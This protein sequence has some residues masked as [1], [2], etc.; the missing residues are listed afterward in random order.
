MI[1][2]EGKRV[3][4]VGNDASALAATALARARGAEVR[5]WDAGS[6]EVPGSDLPDLVVL[7]A[8]CRVMP[9]MGCWAVQ[10]EIPVIGERE[11]AFQC[12]LCLHVAVTGACGKSTTVELLA[13][14][15]R[16]AGRRV[17]TAD[18]EDRPACGWVETSRDLDFLVHAIHP[19]EPEH[20]VYFRPVVAV[21]LNAPLDP[22][23]GETTG[24]EPMRRMSR[25]FAMQQAFDWAIVQSEALAV[26]RAVEVDLPGKLITFS[27]SSR[28]A[29][30]REE[31]GL[32]L[33]GLDGWSG[34]LWD[35][36]KGRMP[37]PHFAENALAALAAGRVLRLTLEQMLPSLAQFRAGPGRMEVLGEIGGVR[38]IDDGRSTTPNALSR[39]LSTLAPTTPD[40]PFVWLVAGGE[41]GG[42]QFYDL[43]P[44]LSP[45]VRHAFVLGEAASAMRSAW[46][47]FVPC[48]PAASLLD[49]VDRAMA[50]AEPGDV[51]LF[52]PACPI[53]DH[54]SGFAA[55]SPSFR[56]AFGQRAS[57]HSAAASAT[58]P[59]AG[60]T[61]TF[62]PGKNPTSIGA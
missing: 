15:L 11:L 45:R 59:G 36:S 4:V 35:L 46:S 18:F 41:S 48:S 37:G 56:E 17:E 52:S 38:W 24:M 47:L 13:Q 29:D 44:A 30:L 28:Q 42:R 7:S 34:P 61:S 1:D 22:M 33:S 49:A 55:G 39:A 2:L 25:L 40:R 50:E 8:G 54:T 10:R 26:L 5:A 6:A 31:R 53:R 23:G 58:G 19:S 62:E 57:Q 3:I 60:A 14:I 21:L 12:S 43:G 16:G 27:A 20:F 9:P 51:I 32:L